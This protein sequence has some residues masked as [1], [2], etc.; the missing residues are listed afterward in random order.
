MIK[1]KSFCSILKDKETKIDKLLINNKRAAEEL[2]E[3]IENKIFLLI[4]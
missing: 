4:Q 1:I 2:K 3:K